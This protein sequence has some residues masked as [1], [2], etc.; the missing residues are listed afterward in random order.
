MDSSRSRQLR[1]FVV[2]VTN[3]PAVM[4]G[5]LLG[6]VDACLLGARGPWASPNSLAVA[7]GE[8]HGR[9][10]LMRARR[11]YQQREMIREMADRRTRISVIFRN[12][13]Q[14]PARKRD[15]GRDSP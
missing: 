15:I 1:M 13:S 10:E 4:F 2:A 11:V 6:W 3:V 12:F 9:R 5:W 14:I 7:G 8:K